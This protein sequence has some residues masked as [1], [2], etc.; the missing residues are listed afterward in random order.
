MP[1]AVLLSLLRVG[2]SAATRGPFLS[3]RASSESAAQVGHSGSNGSN[4]RFFK[5]HS[6]ASI[7]DLSPQVSGPVLEVA[8]VRWASRSLRFEG[9]QP[10]TWDSF[11]I[12]DNRIEEPVL[13]PS[14][15][16]YGKPI[17]RVSGRVSAECV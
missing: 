2:R 7:L 14:S 9:E 15:I 17:P 4:T 6:L 10:V 16:R 1:S 5:P 3:V 12:W 11:G 8:G 13:L